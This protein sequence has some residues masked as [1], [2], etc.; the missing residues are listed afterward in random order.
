MAGWPGGRRVLGDPQGKRPCSNAVSL[1]ATSS[2]LWA[3]T[4]PLRSASLPPSCPTTSIF[5]RAKVSSNIFPKWP[6]VPLTTHPSALR[7]LLHHSGATGGEASPL[8]TAHGIVP[9]AVG[10][11]FVFGGRSPSLLWMLSGGERAPCIHSQP[12]HLSV[13]PVAPPNTQEGKK[14][15]TKPLEMTQL[16]LAFFSKNPPPSNKPLGLPRG[17]QCRVGVRGGLQRGE[18]ALGTPVFRRG[19]PQ[20]RGGWRNG[21]KGENGCSALSALQARLGYVPTIWNKSSLS[22]GY[23]WHTLSSL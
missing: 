11:L 9:A 18:Q 17:E 1:P 12:R 13:G 3:A 5:K 4:A 19:R 14:G 2:L 7:H 20:R 21:D 8:L 23:F 16:S 22:R 10:V 15:E 6:L